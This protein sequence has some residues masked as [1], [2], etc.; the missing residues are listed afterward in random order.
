MKLASTLWG[1]HIDVLFSPISLWA[2]RT[3]RK[4]IEC[5]AVQHDPNWSAHNWPTVFFLKCPFFDAS[6]KAQ[7]V[8]QYW[9]HGNQVWYLTPLTRLVISS[10]MCYIKITCATLTFATL[11]CVTLLRYTT[12]SGMQPQSCTILCNSILN[13]SHIT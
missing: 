6:P 5:R 8:A 2:F 13:P 3:Q 11:D 9:W 10:S 1:H 12:S 4:S 7:N